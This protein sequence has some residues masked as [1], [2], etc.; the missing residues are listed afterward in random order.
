MNNDWKSLATEAVFIVLLTV[1]AYIPA[2]R[3]DFIW[4]DDTLITDNRMIK[5]ADGLQRF[6]ITTEAADYYPLTQTLW[7]LE[8]RLWGNNPLGYHLINVLLHAVNA[9]L[10]W[11]ILRHLKIPGAW[12]AGLVFALHPVNVATVAW[13]SEQKNTL[14]MLFYAVAILSYLKFDEKGGWRWYGLSAGT[15]LLALFS[16]SAVVVLPVVLLG[17]VWW[18]RGRLQRKDV[19]RT[20]PLFA[21]SLIFGLVT[22]WFQ[23]NRALG[24]LAFRNVGLPYRLAA[25]GW[26]PWFYLYKA[27]L[28]FGLT[29][30]YP[31]WTIDASLWI[32]YVPGSLLLGCLAC[33]WWKRNTWGRP[34]L[35]GI[36][37][38]VVTLVPVL[39]FFDQGFYNYSLVADHWQY[40]SIIG[41][42]A[43]VIGATAAICKRMGERGRF[44]GLLAVVILA[45]GLGTATWIR[46]GLYA[47]SEMLW[48]DNVAK[49]PDAWLAHNSLANALMQDGKIEDSIGHYEQAL[50]LKPDYAKAHDNLGVALAQ[51]GKLKEAIPHLQQAVAIDPDL[52]DTHDN[53][54]NA[55]MQ[56]GRLQEAII[57]YE[58]ALRIRPDWFVAYNNLGNALSRA[59][60]QEQAIERYKQALQINP[61]YAEAHNNLGVT[62]FRLGK[63]KE[64]AEQFQLALQIKPDYIEARKNLARVNANQ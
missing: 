9:V 51:S 32:S 12:V 13:I 15:F 21:L 49:N 10:L 17:C 24:A 41:V 27:V 39:G 34:L 3:G 58:L 14:S 45:M 33:C 40:Y 64:A 48:R 61:D 29:V 25:A 35:F 54:G 8:W 16:K 50:Q 47:D 23:H 28:P 18:L 53:L 55:L 38:F 11:L 60:K 63:M 20:A 36:G 56:T 43:L 5:A 62:L 2:Q 1:A 7:W 57:Q 22:I 46:A 44:V 52:A 42:I 4:D 19:L 31:K 6:W 26:A 59:D 37:Y 30:I